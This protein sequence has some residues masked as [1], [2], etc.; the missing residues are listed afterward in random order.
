MYK[1]IETQALNSHGGGGG[2]GWEEPIRGF[3]SETIASLL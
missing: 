3:S 2:G 1:M